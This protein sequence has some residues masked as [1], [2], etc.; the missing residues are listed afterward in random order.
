MQLAIDIGV[1]L[2][3]LGFLVLVLKELATSQKNS[4]PSKPV[5]QSEYTYVMFIRFNVV[6]GMPPRSQTVEA[7]SLQYMQETLNDI[8]FY[9]IKDAR[10]ATNGVVTHQMGPNGVLQPL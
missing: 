1:I 7:N 2:L 3:I 6:E 9:A 8:S 4:V 10:V 5:K